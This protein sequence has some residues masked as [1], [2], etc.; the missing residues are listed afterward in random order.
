[1]PKYDPFMFTVS[2]GIDRD[3][4]LTALYSLVAPTNDALAIAQALV[5]EQ[6]TGT[7]TAVPEETQD[8]KLRSMGRVLGVYEVPDYER[9][10]PPEGTERTLLMQVA[11]PVENINGQFPE[12]LTT[13]YGN[14]SMIGKL[15]L[16]DIAMPPGM[17]K[18]FKGPKFGIEGVRKHL[19]VEGRP[20]LVGMYKPCIGALPDA[21]ARMAYD[22]A[23]GGVDVI[24]DDELMADPKFCPV[25]ARVE[26]T[27]KALDRAR[28]ET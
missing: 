12:L 20:L 17:L 14:V 3:Q 5:T 2:E 13:L 7:W 6:T 24:K 18:S 25:D 9:E 1:M 28:K 11:Y 23:I 22:M 27:E 8:V 15:K 16:L 4:Y 19:G 21:I 26:A 10:R